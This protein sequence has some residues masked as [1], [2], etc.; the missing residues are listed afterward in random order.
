MVIRLE[1]PVSFKMFYGYLG[2]ELFC[3]REDELKGK[4]AGHKRIGRTEYNE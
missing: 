2:L 4:K 3:G 1:R